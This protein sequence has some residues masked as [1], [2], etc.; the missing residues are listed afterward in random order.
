[1]YSHKDKINLAFSCTFLKNDLLRSHDFTKKKFY[2]SIHISLL[3]LE[4]A[5]GIYK[6]K[7]LH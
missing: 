4:P 6:P 3:L 7:K 5:F 1:M 2:T